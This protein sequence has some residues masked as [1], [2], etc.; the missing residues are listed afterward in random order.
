MAEAE[1]GEGEARASWTVRVLGA[2]LGGLLT[3]GALAEAADLYRMVGLVLYNEQ[4]LVMLLGI[5]IATLFVVKPARTKT[6]RLRVPWYDGLAAVAGLVVCAWVAWDY[7]RIFEN[8]H[9]RPTDAIAASV[10]RLSCWWRRG[11]GGP[12]AGSCSGS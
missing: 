2:W 12:P 3:A 8:L 5:G 4:R 6:E 1:R 11:S 7:E 10:D 9:F